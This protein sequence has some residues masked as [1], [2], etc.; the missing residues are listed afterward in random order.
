MGKTSEWLG[1][2]AF[3]AFWG[4]FMFLWDAITNPKWFTRSNL[5]KLALASLVVGMGHEFEWRILHGKLAVLFGAAIL[6]ALVLGL[7]ERRARRRAET[8]SMVG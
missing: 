7:A 1:V 2:I 3:G 4:L 6:G 5:V 8:S